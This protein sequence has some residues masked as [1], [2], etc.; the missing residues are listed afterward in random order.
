MKK[1]LV[2][3]SGGREHALAWKIAASPQVE[4][5]FFAPGNAA[6]FEK[7]EIIPIAMSDVPS[8]IHFVKTN[9]VYFTVVGPEAPLA[10]GLVDAF[11]KEGLPVFG[12]VQAAAALESSKVFA[13]EIMEASRVPTAKAR[14]FSNP[15]EARTYVQEVGAPLVIKADGLAA[16]KGVIVAHDLS[17]ALD[18]VR[19]CLEDQRFGSSGAHILVEEFLPGKEASV[20]AIISDESI[21]MLPISSDYKR[22]YDNHEGPNTGGMGAITPTP[23]LSES[24]LEDLKS[25]V[26]LPVIRKLK[27]RGIP[28]TGFLY[29]GLMVLP[30]GSRKVLEFNCRL[31]DPET[32]PLMLRID[33]DLFSI[34]EKALFAPETLPPQVKCTDTTAITVV[35]ASKGY[36]GNVDDGKE[37]H[38]LDKESDSPVI[39]FQAGTKL[40][41]GKILSSGGRILTVTTTGRDLDEVRDKVYGAIKKISFEGMEYRTDIGL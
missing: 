29:A 18:A 28:Y 6:S 8:L 33:E 21:C 38:G 9:E 41:D 31:G 37:I 12:P 2:I 5:V 35:L 25:E 40:V 1:I 14:T 17:T 34:L 39:V 27:E 26:F 13:K 10:L 20:M 7:C 4:K 11:Q 32:Q 23:V 3:G 24:L 30:D 16:G 36:P 15:D 19:D 22:A